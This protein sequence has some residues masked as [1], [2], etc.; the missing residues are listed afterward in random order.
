MA[1]FHGHTATA[2]A[3]KLHHGQLVLTHMFG[4]RIRCTAK[5]AFSVVTAGAAQVPWFVGDGTASF[6]SIGHDEPPSENI[7]FRLNCFSVMFEYEYHQRK[8]QGRQH[9][10][11]VTPK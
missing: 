6:T 5:A 10:Q 8:S 9:N 2:I 3:Y 11:R 4:I 7:L 1:L